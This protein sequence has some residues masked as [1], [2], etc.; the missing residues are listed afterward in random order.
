MQAFEPMA[1]QAFYSLT[2]NERWD[3][4]HRYAASAMATATWTISSRY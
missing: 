2:D 3:R 4:L 1:L